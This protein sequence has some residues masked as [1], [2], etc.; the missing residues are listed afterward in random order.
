MGNKVCM[1]D[2][3]ARNGNIM[4]DIVNLCFVQLGIFLGTIC[5]PFLA[6]VLW[7]GPITPPG[8]RSGHILGVQPIRYSISSAIVIKSRDSHMT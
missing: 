5:S 1:D 7:L 4:G 2:R 6:Q 3:Q 8:S